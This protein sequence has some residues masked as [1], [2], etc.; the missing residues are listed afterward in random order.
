MV[1]K[2]EI[3]L[4]VYGHIYEWVKPKRRFTIHNQQFSMIEGGKVKVVE[5]SQKRIL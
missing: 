1:N 5:C 4:L 2:K 3:D